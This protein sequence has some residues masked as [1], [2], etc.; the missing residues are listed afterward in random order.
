MSEASE[1]DIDTVEYT[2]NISKEIAESTQISYF[3]VEH[4]NSIISN[5]IEIFDLGEEKTLAEKQKS[6]DEEIQKRDVLLKKHQILHKKALHKLTE[7]LE[8]ERAKYRILESSVEEKIKSSAEKARLEHCQEA[9]KNAEE[10][11]AIISSYKQREAEIKKEHDEQIKTM[12]KDIEA[13]TEI[14][15]A[16]F[17]DDTER[18]SKIRVE[19]TQ[20]ELDRLS[21]VKIKRIEDSYI[22]QI[23]SNTE[24]IGSLKEDLIKLQERLAAKDLQCSTI[25]EKRSEEVKQLLDEIKIERELHAHAIE[26][27]VKELNLQT[28]NTI[29]EHKQREETIKS[30][31]ELSIAQMQASLNREKDLIK[32]SAKKELENFEIKAAAD[33]ANLNSVILSHQETIANIKQQLKATALLYEGHLKLSNTT[34]ETKKESVEMLTEI[35]QHITSELVPVNKFLGGTNQEK[36]SLGENF[37]LEVLQSNKR[38]VGAEIIHVAHQSDEGDLHFNWEK[39]KCLIE[40]KNKKIITPGDIA[41]F[42]SNVSSSSVNSGLFISLQTG[43]FGNTIRDLISYDTINEKPIV[44][45]Y[46][47]ST[48]LSSIEN[49]ILSLNHILKVSESNSSTDNQAQLD[50][51]ISYIGRQRINLA[52]RRAKLTAEIKSI[53]RE[54]IEISNFAPPAEASNFRAGKRISAEPGQNSDINSSPKNITSVESIEETLLQSFN[55]GFIPDLSDVSVDESVDLTAV[56]SKAKQKFILSILTPDKISILVDHYKKNSRHM[57]RAELENNR[58]LSQGELRKLAV[59]TARPHNSICKIID[60]YIKDSNPKPVIKRSKIKQNI[61]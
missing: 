40:I 37:V 9:Q 13:Q 49:P 6:T 52:S 21:E 15:F 57:T 35:K 23:K 28:E 45:L 18:V 19:Q 60:T 31:Y 14:R 29:H 12:V 24:T 46:L 47:D 58:I 20:D 50:V 51:Y 30:T 39:L 61:S 53:D 56:I 43:K 4:W 33:R 16:K 32:E 2:I 8:N 42:K 34:A 41:K 5:A 55:S 22:Q 25:S 44:Y 54:L 3:Q 7:E 1:R 59:V 17:K 48:N 38:F 26:K 11:Q 36:G 10:L 27:K